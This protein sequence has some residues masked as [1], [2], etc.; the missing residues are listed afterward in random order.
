MKT[1]PYKPVVALWLL[2]LGLAFVFVYA[3][4]SSLMRPLTWIG[5]LPAAATKV[6][7]AATLLKVLAVYEIVLALW[8]CTGKYTRYAAAL[9]ALTLTGIV[10]V[11]TT[12]MLTTFRDV[13]LAAAAVA[14]FCLE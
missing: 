7:A 3:G 1:A 8:L 11:N 14:L 9:A 10:A 4:V 13:G 5:F 6:I 2:R 12:N